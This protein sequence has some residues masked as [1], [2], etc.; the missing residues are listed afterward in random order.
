M[1]KS[2]LNKATPWVAFFLAIVPPATFAGLHHDHAEHAPKPSN[3]QQQ[4][5]QAAKANYSH[6][7]ED[8]ATALKLARTRLQIANATGD[9]HY[10]DVIPALL[11]PW[12]T[13]S[14]NIELLVVKAAYWQHTHDFKQ[15]R[16]TLENVL[17]RT[18]GHV[19]ASLILSSIEAAEGQ[20]AASRS[21]CGPVVTQQAA[22]L[23]A[24]CLGQSVASETAIKQ[25]LSLIRKRPR[26]GSAEDRWAAAIQLELQQRLQRGHYAPK[27][28]HPR[29]AQAPG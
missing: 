17:A 27:A 1:C 23:G 13:N 4:G 25:S 10:S 24:A 29:H 6:H 2:R 28:A 21:A 14:E 8:L 15:S 20:W 18:P 11:A 26:D 9:T 3:A 12:W 7:P 22:W 16:H 19:Q 5:L